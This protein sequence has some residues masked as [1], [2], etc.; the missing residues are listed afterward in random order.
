[1]RIFCLPV[2]LLAFVFSSPARADGASAQAPSGSVK[3][4]VKQGTT[5]YAR[6]N[7]E[8]A[9]AAFLKAWDLKQHY[10]I[11]GSLADVEM[12]L[13]R[14]REAAEHLKY[15]I[16]NLPPEHADKRAEADASL[17]ECRAHLASVR[18][19]VSGPLVLVKLDGQA[20]PYASL[21]D[22]VLLEPGPHKL[23]ATQEGYQTSM[24]EFVAVAGE[25]REMQL[26]LAPQAQPPRLD[27]ANAAHVTAVAPS[28][29]TPDSAKASHTSARTWALIGGGAATVVAAG[30]GTYFTLHYF[31]LRSDASQLL[32]Q[33]EAEGSPALVAKH[34][35][36]QPGA[37][38]RPTACDQLA[39][40]LDSRVTAANLSNASWLA[41]G[42]LG[43]ATVTTYL[44]WPTNGNRGANKNA[45]VSI[46]PWLVGARGG[47]LQVDF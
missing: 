35:Q 32:A 23:E 45:H 1:M 34:E 44:L 41:A 38:M 26:E 8:A 13:G 15:A 24:R 14:Y 10:A 33:T 21:H 4:L 18:V 19:S 40:A 11:A 20:L 7:W 37:P 9:R 39:H 36:C 17:K 29:S 16:A 22:E 12:K 25:A 28:A 47:A 31:S 3:G 43:A 46:A 30:L 6:H 42:V 2:A 27:S 5:E